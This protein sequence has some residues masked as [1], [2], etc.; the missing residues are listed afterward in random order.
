MLRRCEGLWE[1]SVVAVSV[2]GSI[3]IQTHERNRL[4]H[5]QADCAAAVQNI[6][7]TAQLNTDSKA[8]ERTLGEDMPTR[9]KSLQ[10]RVS[11]PGVTGFVFAC[12]LSC[13]IRSDLKQ[14]VC[15]V[16]ELTRHVTTS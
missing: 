7:V 11:Q 12:A 6:G 1:V 9:M 15:G 13:I 2:S 5:P 3:I 8:E 14:P 16:E 4:R 10:G